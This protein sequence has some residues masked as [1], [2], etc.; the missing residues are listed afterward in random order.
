MR[1]QLG[2]RSDRLDHIRKP[3][4]NPSALSMLHDLLRLLPILVHVKLHELSLAWD[5]RI[6][7]LVKRAARQSRDL[8]PAP[9][10]TTEH[11]PNTKKRTKPARS[12]IRTGSCAHHRTH[13]HAQRREGK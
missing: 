5:R 13:T 7:D 11:R 6:D 12:L 3:H 4:L 10:N 9:Y 2:E 8:V 1:S